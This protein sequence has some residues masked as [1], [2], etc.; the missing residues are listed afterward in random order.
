[1]NRMASLTILFHRGVRKYRWSAF[2]RMALETQ[3]PRI[4]GVDHM[5]THA[6]VWSMAGR[7]FNFPLK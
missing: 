2:I 4:V 5:F 7:A 6:A 3:F 1:M